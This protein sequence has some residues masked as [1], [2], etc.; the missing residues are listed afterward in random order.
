MGHT[1]GKSDDEDGNN[2]IEHTVTGTFLGSSR[3]WIQTFLPA[4]L[5]VA[6]KPG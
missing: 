3:E 2:F 1:T 6:G 4:L 5:T